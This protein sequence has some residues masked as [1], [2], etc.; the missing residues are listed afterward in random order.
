MKLRPKILIVS[1]LVLLTSLI[2]LNVISRLILLDNYRQLEQRSVE[3]N[4]DRV[5]EDVDDDLTSIGRMNADW[6]YWDQSARFIQDHNS[7]YIDENL[8]VNTFIN[9]HINVMM[10]FDTSGKVVFSRAVD[11]DRG[12]EIP[13]P[14]GLDRYLKANSSFLH[15]ESDPESLV[16]GTLLLDNGA[17][18]VTTRAILNDAHQPPAGGTLLLGRFLNNKEIAS[19]A[20]SLNLNLT[21]YNVNDSQLPDDVTVAREMLAKSA[22]DTLVRPLSDSQVAGYTVSRTPDG[23]PVLFWRITLPREIYAQG[24]AS[25]SYFL[26]LVFVVGLLFTFISL[27]V[28]ERFVL[29]RLAHLHQSVSAIRQSGDLNQ[30][31]N[32]SGHDELA[33]LAT[34]INGLIQELDSTQRS[35]KQTLQFKSDLLANVSHDTRSPLSTIKLRAEMLQLGLYGPLNAQQQQSVE[36][37]RGS[38]DQLLFFINNLLDASRLEAKSVTLVRQSFEPADLLRN[39]VE[40]MRIQAE[41]KGIGMT[42]TLLDDVAP[43]LYGDPE[44]LTQI[45]SNL[46][47]NAIKFT[48]QGSISVSLCQPD[49]NHLRIDVADTG[50]G[51]APEQQAQLFQAFYQVDQSMTRQHMQGVG[52]GLSIVKQL[53]D[54]MEGT[55]SLESS[56]GVGTTFTIHLPLTSAGNG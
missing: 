54:L 51:I 52:L 5:R 25:I 28:L 27:L 18:L 13:V 55:I 12:V 8:G 3:S 14:T 50:R 24:N 22:S 48:D 49:V 15:H 46:I 16:E 31:I 9:L 34:A 41:Q 2:V 43:S 7:A 37:I 23:E 11:L 38:T 35:L 47:G 39:L 33:E 4:L 42:A 10:Y 1:T 32:L 30:K 6:A 29:A 44:R 26:G 40:S 20:D 45:L 17:I 19:I 56:L 53:V 21:A 36:I